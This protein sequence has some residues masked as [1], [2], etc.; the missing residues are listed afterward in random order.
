MAADNYSDVVQAL[1]QQ[2]VSTC[3]KIIGP[4]VKSMISNATIDAS[5]IS[6]EINVGMAASVNAG[7]VIGLNQVIVSAIA[8]SNIDISQIVRFD[9]NVGLIIRSAQI[10]KAQI[11]DLTA[12]VARIAK[13]EIENATI[14]YAQVDQLDAHAAN[15]AD[16]R[17]ANAKIGSTQIDW[18]NIT[19]ANV[20]D[21]VAEN[22]IIHKGVN[23]KLYV[24]DLAVTEA[25]MVSLS[26]G[27][28]MVKG[29][30]GA[31]YS[32]GIDPKSD[33]D[34]PKVIATKKHVVT[35]DI[36]DLAVT[37]GKIADQTINGDVKMIESSIT[38]RTL[39]VQDIFAD[40]A[41]IRQLIAANI[42]V[43]TLFAREGTIAAINTMDIRGNQYLKL[44]VEDYI[45]NEGNGQITGIAE[46]AFIN[47][48][49][50]LIAAK[51]TRSET[52][53]DSMKIGSRNYIRFSRDVTWDGHHGEIGPAPMADFAI[54]DVSIL[55][56]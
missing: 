36:D 46:N 44:G 3:M 30:D 31:F 27:E 32:I 26:V 13:A 12:E 23:G 55:T 6:G 39:N 1:A 9:E 8:N 24:A 2:I 17:I 29:P 4:N 41:I 20:K 56:E 34:N 51:V 45:E 54:A 40:S 14:N 35:S 5:Q 47:M 42:D 37:G 19:W 50:D 21:L 16:A 49:D 43:D 28:L 10:D 7:D 52:F 11:T 18:A 25:N 38:A 48:A 15:I 33:R 53:R 22:S